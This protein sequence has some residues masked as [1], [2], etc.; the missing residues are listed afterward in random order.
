MLRGF[1]K[2]GISPVVASVLLIM[3]AVVTAT[4]IAVF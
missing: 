4:L 2:R 3:I 1:S